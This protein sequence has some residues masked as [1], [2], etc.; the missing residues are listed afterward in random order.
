MPD[1]QLV[2]WADWKQAANWK[3]RTYLWQVTTELLRG[4]QVGQDF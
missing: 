1:Y 2:V 3:E 4:A